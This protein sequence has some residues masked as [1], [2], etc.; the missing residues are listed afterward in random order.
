[1]NGKVVIKYY[2]RVLFDKRQWWMWSTSWEVRFKRERR[3]KILSIIC[4][5]WPQQRFHHFH[6]SSIKIKRSNWNNLYYFSRFVLLKNLKIEHRE[7]DCS[8]FSVFTSHRSAIHSLLF[9]KNNRTLVCFSFIFYFAP[10]VRTNVMFCLIFF[11]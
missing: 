7:Y 4:D 8:F 3:T 1:M 5:L 11:I 2:L 6:I 10:L 9:I